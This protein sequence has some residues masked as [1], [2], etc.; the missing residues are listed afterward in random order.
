MKRIALTGGIGTGKTHVLRLFRQHGIP[1]LDADQISRAVVDVGQPSYYLVRNRF[2]DDYFFANG[3]LNRA[4]LAQL[5]FTNQTARA[6]L[7]AI[8]HPAVRRLIDDWFT[9]CEDSGEHHIAIAEIPLLFETN[10][11]E[12]FDEVVVVSCT[13]AKQIS[14]VMKRDN[15][16]EDEAQ[17]RLA[18]QLPIADKMSASSWVIR[19]DGSNPA[20]AKQVERFSIALQT[21]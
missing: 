7:E 4:L 2:E 13:P 10:R 12:E 14:R 15:L 11:T 5:V 21:A 19:T 17:Q 3:Q 20:T 1:T 6:D 9:R 16:S 18:A 8:V